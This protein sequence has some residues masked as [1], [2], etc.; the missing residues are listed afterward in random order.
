[1]ESRGLALWRG[2]LG[3]RK[4]PTGRSALTPT[5]SRRTGEGGSVAGASEQG[6]LNLYSAGR[7]IGEHKASAKTKRGAGGFQGVARG[8]HVVHEIGLAQGQRLAGAGEVVL[9]GRDGAK[10]VLVA[11]ALRGNRLGAVAVPPRD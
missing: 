7:G 10:G 3:L 1:M 4:S 5:L 9:V 11:G 6:R 8:C 2:G